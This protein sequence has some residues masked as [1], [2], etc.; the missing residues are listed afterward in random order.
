MKY[1]DKID[2]LIIHLMNMS[3]LYCHC[4]K[5][6]N[7]SS[8]LSRRRGLTLLEVAHSTTG[9]TSIKFLQIQNEQLPVWGLWG[10]YQ[11]PDHVKLTKG[12]LDSESGTHIKKNPYLEKHSDSCC[13]FF[14]FIFRQGRQCSQGSLRTTLPRLSGNQ[15]HRLNYMCTFGVSL[16]NFQFEDMLSA[17]IVVIAWRSLTLVLWFLSVLYFKK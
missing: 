12:L 2:Q 17:A 7:L 15:V 6:A 1:P 16:K 8:D 3:L 11:S 5:I 10:F 13:H 9:Q 14:S 4:R